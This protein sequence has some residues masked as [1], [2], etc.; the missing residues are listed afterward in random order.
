MGGNNPISNA[1]DEVGSAIS[2]VGADVD[3][4]VNE[5]IPG[6]WYTV[7]AVAGGTYLAN[8]GALAGAA[9]AGTAATAAEAGTAAA[10]AAETAAAGEALGTGLTA[11]SSGMGFTAGATAPELAAMGGGTGLTT[12]AA[13]GGT[14]GA[15]GVTAAGAVPMLGEAGSIINAPA[16]LGTDV[17]G[18]Q[19]PMNIRSAVDT[20]RT[21]N[22]IRNLLGQP[23]AQIPPMQRGMIQP[24][25]SVQY[26]SLSLLEMRPIQRPTTLI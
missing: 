14:L 22:S 8:S 26:P 2:D 15:T 6:G 25:G 13:G 12:G 20:L 5:E 1:I 24:Q 3:D 17:V 19:A 7:G 4:F 9:E 18:Y 10:T 11:G 23:T 21:A 16:V